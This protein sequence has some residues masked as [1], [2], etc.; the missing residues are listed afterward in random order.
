LPRE[1]LRITVTI[2]GETSRG[3]LFEACGRQYERLLAQ[4]P[5]CPNVG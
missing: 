2:T 3:F 4:L 1:Q 5:Q